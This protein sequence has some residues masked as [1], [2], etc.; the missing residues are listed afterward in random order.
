MSTKIY[1]AYRLRSRLDLWKFLRYVRRRAEQYARERIDAFADELHAAVDPTSRRFQELLPSHHCEWEVREHIAWDFLHQAYRKADASNVRS[2]VDLSLALTVREH[3]GRYYFI[4]Y[5]G[6][7]MRGALTDLLDRS[8]L[9]EDFHYQN[10]TDRP[11]EISEAEWERRRRTWDAMGAGDDAW[12]NYLTLEIVSPGSFWRL[13]TQVRRW[14]L[15]LT[16][17]ERAS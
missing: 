12:W 9:V 13:A 4:A 3:E 16:R 5:E 15:H 7:G 6:D 1:N 8:L 17:E 2:R 11:D 14:E 10:S